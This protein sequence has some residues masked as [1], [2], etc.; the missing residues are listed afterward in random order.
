MFLRFGIPHRSWRVMTA[1]KLNLLIIEADK[2]SEIPEVKAQF[3]ACWDVFVG[4]VAT[5]QTGGVYRRFRIK[6]DRFISKRGE[7]GCITPFI[8][9]KEG[10]LVL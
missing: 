7:F 6:R 1:T 4:S 10:R 3:V 5:F 8:Q 2:D 9:M